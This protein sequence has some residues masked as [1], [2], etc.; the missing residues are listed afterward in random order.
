MGAV[1]F[2]GSTS[3]WDTDG[4]S[5]RTSS[6][7]YTR[8]FPLSGEIVNRECPH[9]TAKNRN[10]T[11]DRNDRDGWARAGLPGYTA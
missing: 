9:A 6:A 3:G 2:C 7:T 4:R 10:V 1:R 11:F 5:A 8:S